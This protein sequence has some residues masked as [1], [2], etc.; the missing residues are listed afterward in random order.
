[1]YKKQIIELTNAVAWNEDALAGSIAEK[2]ALQELIYKQFQQVRR[3]KKEL[4]LLEQEQIW[5]D[6][7]NPKCPILRWLRC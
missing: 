7:L 3:V 6:Y 5:Y 4:K 1:M 2:N